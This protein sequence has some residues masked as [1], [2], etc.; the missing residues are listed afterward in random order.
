MKLFFLLAFLVG[1]LWGCSIVDESY[2]DPSHL[3][4]I[5]KYCD[6][7]GVKGS[8]AFIH[9]RR[10]AYCGWVSP[11]GIYSSLQIPATVL[12]PYRIKSK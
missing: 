6:S 12:N 7:T 1:L 3:P 8:T 5:Q 11:T 2:I 10:Y 9:D 4:E